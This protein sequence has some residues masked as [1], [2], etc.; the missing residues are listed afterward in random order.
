[1]K[2]K[3][4]LVSALTP[5]TPTSIIDVASGE[6][7]SL[8]VLGEKITQM[9]DTVVGETER[10]FKAHQSGLLVDLL[11]YRGSPQPAEFARQAGYKTNF[12]DV[13]SREVKAV[14]RLEKLVQYKLVSE[15]ASYVA[16]PTSNKQ[17]PRFSATINLGA[18]DKQMASISLDGSELNLLWKCWDKEYYITFSIPAYVLKREVSKFS[19]P[20]VR[21]DKR[22]GSV[23]F[24]FSVYEDVKPRRGNK[25]TVGID[26]GII[27]PYSI[28]VVN[29]VG[30]RVASY[31]ATSRLTN[32]SNKRY[33]L[34]TEKK[35]IKAKI[36]NRANR[37]LESS[38]Q[39]LE[40][41]RVSDKATRLTKT[42]AQQS[43]SEIAKK[44]TK[45]NTNTIHLEQLNWVSGYTGS[46]I[47]SSRW[48]HSQQQDAIT[49]ATARA[50]FKT[51]KVSAKNTSNTCHSCGSKI[52]HNTKLR[53]VRCSSCQSVLDRDFNA[54]M[55][56]AKQSLLF[57]VSQKLNGDT[58]VTN[59]GVALLL[60]KEVFSG[61]FVNSL[62]LMTR[63]TT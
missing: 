51:K 38:Q 7:V 22:N 36:T 47:G 59:S 20:V 23:G 40:L 39:E 9:M 25:H 31:E 50:G 16:N 28:A 14:S 55:N 13:L 21:F 62:S 44:L 49:H 57:P 5:L 18:V 63:K 43:G 6:F 56:I 3:N 52:T 32:L 34:L 11:G 42:I 41:G 24:I 58:T 17:L 53:T 4:Q 33:R 60:G 2:Q 19:L 45:H 35:H 46:K 27:K 61:A 48:S 54:A 1:M 12:R 30:E 26:L 10:L 8:S 15:T 37:N 29:K